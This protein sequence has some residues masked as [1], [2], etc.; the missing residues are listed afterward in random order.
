MAQLMTL[1][2]TA[3]Y[4]RV[5]KKTIYRLLRRGVIPATKIGHQWRFDKAAIGEWLHQSSVGAKA[6]FFSTRKEREELA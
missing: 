5:T 4:L 1:E 6:P 3:N 2:E